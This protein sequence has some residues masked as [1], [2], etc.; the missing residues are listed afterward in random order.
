LAPPTPQP[1]SF[2]LTRHEWCHFAIRGEIAI[3]RIRGISF[4]GE[5]NT[6][7]YLRRE[8]R[9]RLSQARLERP[10]FS[11]AASYEWCFTAYGS[12][13]LSYT[14]KYCQG[15]QSVCA[16][17]VQVRIDGRQKELSSYP[18]GHVSEIFHH[19]RY[20]HWLAWVGEVAAP[21]FCGVPFRLPWRT[22]FLQGDRKG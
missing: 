16:F 12:N 8:H 20:F 9:P 4:I 18:P 15:C 2:V 3:P 11:V 19:V 1:R 13:H 21:S 5:S 10:S 6:D 22:T 7:S 17:L 14:R